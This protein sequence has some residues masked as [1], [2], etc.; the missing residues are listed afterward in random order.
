LAAPE[1]CEAHR[2]QQLDWVAHCDPAWLDDRTVG[3]P[4]AAEFADN[5]PP[6][7]RVLLLSIRIV[8]G[9]HAAGAKLYNIAMMAVPSRRREPGH[10]RSASP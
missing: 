6:N 1:A 7:G 4:A 8:R 5:A 2:F 3:R 9:H 10:D